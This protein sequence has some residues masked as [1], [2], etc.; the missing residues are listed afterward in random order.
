MTASEA[1]VLSL[2]ESDGDPSPSRRSRN[3]SRTFN[4]ALYGLD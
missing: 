2:Q 3:A 4:V 1:D